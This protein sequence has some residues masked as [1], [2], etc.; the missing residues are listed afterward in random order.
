MNASFSAAFLFLVLAFA[1]Y[2][3]AVH[4]NTDISN[5][6]STV[7]KDELESNEH[8]D[9]LFHTRAGPP[10]PGFRKLLKEEEP[11]SPPEKGKKPKAPWWKRKPNSPCIPKRKPKPKSPKP[12][13]H[14]PGGRFPPAWPPLTPLR[15]FRTRLQEPITLVS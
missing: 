11:T 2:T 5:T 8:R 4:P 14:H 15:A 10:G 3:N 6:F 1:N 12:P 13:R 7:I 9:A